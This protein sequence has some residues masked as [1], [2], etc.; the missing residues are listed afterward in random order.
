MKLK[1]NGENFLIDT[2]IFLEILL[3]QEK[4]D[5]CENLLK[6]ISKKK[7]IFYVSSFSIHSIE[8][9][10]TRNKKDIALAE[11]LSFIEKS[12]I[13]RIESITSDEINALDN[14]KEIKLDFDDALQ[15]TLCKKHNLTLV[16][17][18]KH[19]DKTDIT[20]T[21]PSSLLMDN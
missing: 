18:D 16:S 2:N 12:K 11:F 15:L 6:N 20:R 8:V 21:E 5:E 9:I 3:N 1:M 19:F 17:Y 13:I 7:S 4:A 10:M 14:M